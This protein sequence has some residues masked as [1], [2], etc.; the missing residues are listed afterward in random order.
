MIHFDGKS[1]VITASLDTALRDA[2]CDLALI[3]VGTARKN[4]WKTKAAVAR[5]QSM[6]DA[7]RSYSSRDEVGLVDLVRARRGMGTSDAQDIVYAQ[8]GMAEMVNK[9]PAAMKVDYTISISQLYQIFARHMLKERTAGNRPDS[10]FGYLV[11]Q[12]DPEGFKARGRPGPGSTRRS[13]VCLAPLLSP[14]ILRPTE[15][16]DSSPELLSSWVLD[17]SKTT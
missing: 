16:P 14:V 13:F 1:V 15:V 17:A 8:C 2:F 12:L 4:D 9:W 3:G 10:G 7:H 6:D 11:D 5:L